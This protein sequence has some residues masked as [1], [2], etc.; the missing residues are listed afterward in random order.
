MSDDEDERE[1]GDGEFLNAVVE[2][3]TI[4]DDDPQMTE[5]LLS[6]DPRQRS[7]ESDALVRIREIARTVLEGRRRE[8][9]GG[10]TLCCCLC[11]HVR[12]G[13]ASPADTI[14]NGHAVCYDHM[15]YV[16]GGQFSAALSV[17]REAEARRLGEEAD[18]A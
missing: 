5:E 13:V 11:L 12:E 10:V 17:A 8:P 7:A 6:S 16:Q 2:I 14:I 3:L 15:G 18:Q 1:T 9:A 4:F